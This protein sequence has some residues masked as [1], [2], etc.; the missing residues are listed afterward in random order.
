MSRTHDPLTID[1]E[2]GAP[3]ILGS[4]SKYEWGRSGES[5]AIWR[6]RKHTVVATY[7]GPRGRTN[8]WVEF[9]ALE[10]RAR[11]ERRRRR[12]RTGV[13]VGV[14]ALAGAAV[15][16]VL[17]T[18]DEVVA[19][20]GPVPGGTRTGVQRFQDPSGRYAFR[21]PAGWGLTQDATS[22]Q[23]FGPDDSVVVSIGPAPAG[24]P[25]TVAPDLAAASTEAWGD[26]Q[27][28]VVRPQ[29]VG[30]VQASSVGGAGTD[31]AGT[32][33]RFLVIVVP[34]GVDNISITVVVPID[35]E[36]SVATPGIEQILATFRLAEG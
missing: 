1:G 28:E 21:Y 20:P 4:G 13:V 9:Q 16:A 33:V 14:L 18:R 5:H 11:R 24:D 36:P 22:T 34:G 31:A 8:A 6:S 10:T 7:G 26:V 30:T 12:V 17:V 3:E 32:P 25:A 35:A 2:D 15:A 29:L 19:T 23:V 27:L